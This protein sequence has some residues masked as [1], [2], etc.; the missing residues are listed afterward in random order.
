MANPSWESVG[1]RVRAAARLPLDDPSYAAETQKI[2]EA[3]VYL[4]TRLEPA[5]SK[6]E[7]L[8]EWRKRSIPQEHLEEAIKTGRLVV[9]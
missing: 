3:M 5:D 8:G 9:S 7:T 2:G 4:W 6:P 1:R